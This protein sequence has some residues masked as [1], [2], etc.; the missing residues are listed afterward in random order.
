V[1]TSFLSL[2]INYL[3]HTPVVCIKYVDLCSRV[4]KMARAEAPYTFQ[5]T[6][7]GQLPDKQMRKTYTW[8]HTA[9]QSLLLSSHIS[10]RISQTVGDHTRLQLWRLWTTLSIKYIQSI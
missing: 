5:T 9:K 3:V 10:W 4:T 6:L 2:R 8:R 1:H 7:D